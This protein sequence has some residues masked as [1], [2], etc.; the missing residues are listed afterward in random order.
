MH[1]MHRYALGAALVIVLSI[2][3]CVTLPGGGVLPTETVVAPTAAIAADTP[4]PVTAIP[5][6]TPTPSATAI[7]SETPVPTI[8]PT[9]TET[10]IP[11]WHY[12]TGDEVSLW[13]PE[14]WRGGDLQEDLDQLL[15]DAPNEAPEVRQYADVLEENRS[16]IHLWAYDTRSIGSFHLTNVNIGQELVDDVVTVDLYMDAL[17]RNLP[18]GFTITGR[19]LMDIHDYQGGRIFIDVNINGLIIKEVMYIF[20]VVDIMWLVTFAA[21]SDVFDTQLPAFEMSMQT[22][23]I[24]EEA[25]RE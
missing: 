8:T 9:P 11:G 1:D 18:E 20:K 13:L 23:E 15:A 2:A 4:A 7:P 6:V 19:Q 3:G 14:S 25:D 22:V 16:N 17:D 5:S 12:I 21:T 10:S 24:G